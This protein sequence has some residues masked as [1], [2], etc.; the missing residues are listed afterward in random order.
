[1]DGGGMTARP[2]PATAPPA[3]APDAISTRRTLI[4]LLGAGAVRGRRL[5]VEPARLHGATRRP[6][7]DLHLAG[8]VPRS[9]PA[10]RR[11]RCADRLGRISPAPWRTPRL[12]MAGV[13]APAVPD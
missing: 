6:G 5:V 8:H 1:M 10:G 12:A 2:A 11:R 13:V 9:D 3:A 4:G 7:L